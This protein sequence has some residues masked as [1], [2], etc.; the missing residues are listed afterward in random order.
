MILARVIGNVTAS[1][2]H[3]AYQ[4]HKVLIV[5]PIDE[6]G[7]DFGDSFLALDS[8]QAGPGDAVLVA[9]E[10]NCAREI[11]GTKDDPF[12]SVI[13][14]IVDKVDIEVKL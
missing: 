7:K 11:L 10:G 3:P 14:G 13:L 8:V 12:H 4:G 6:T 9:R 5:Q 2:K 1:V